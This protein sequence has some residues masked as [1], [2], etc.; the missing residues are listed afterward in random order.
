MQLI[1]NVHLI[2]SNNV[3]NATA[4]T[5]YFTENLLYNNV[6]TKPAVV[7]PRP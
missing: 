6:T 2:A 7:T 5:A 4:V 1:Q 3:D